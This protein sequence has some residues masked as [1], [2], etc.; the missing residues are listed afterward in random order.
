MDIPREEG[1][2]QLTGL[3]VDDLVNAL[4]SRVKIVF[5]D[6]CRNNPALFKEIVYGR[7]SAPIGLAPANGSSVL[8]GA[9]GRGVFIAYATDSN[10]VALDGAGT[11]SP[12]A[13]ALLNHLADQRSLDDMFSVVTREVMKSSNNKQRPYKPDFTMYADIS[14]G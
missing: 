3:K 8:A 4:R 12:F 13:E 6:A 7:G 5:L 2:I 11:H 1:D 10:S 14:F 9:Q